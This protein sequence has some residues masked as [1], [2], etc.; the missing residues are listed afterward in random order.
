MGTVE[1]RGS[2]GF[3]LGSSKPGGPGAAP[4]CA[5]ASVS[6]MR[7]GAHLGPGPGYPCALSK[8]VHLGVP[9]SEKGDIAG[10]AA[11]ATAAPRDAGDLCNV[12]VVA[13]ICGCM[14]ASP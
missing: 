2:G 14:P 9:G 13:G 12:K 6:P 11:R 10:T 7:E 4:N 1:I 3:I 5:R 8:D